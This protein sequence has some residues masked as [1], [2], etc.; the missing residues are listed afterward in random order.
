MN[1]ITVQK[2]SPE[3]LANHQSIPTKI[4]PPHNL[5][6]LSPA[7]LPKFKKSPLQEGFF[8]PLMLILAYSQNM[9]SEKKIFCPLPW[10]SLCVQPYG[11]A[12]CCSSFVDMRT[13]PD[14][15]PAEVFHNS[16]MTE[17]RRK[18][19][20]GEWP[21]QCHSCEKNERE[22]TLSYRELLLRTG[23]YDDVVQMKDTLDNESSIARWWR[24]L[25]KIAAPLTTR[26]LTIRFLELA[27]SNY[28]NLKCRMCGPRF[29]SKWNEDLKKM[30]DSGL[31]EEM[32]HIS[33]LD[34][35]QPKEIGPDSLLELLSS[36]PKIM[37]KGGEPMLNRH[38]A[39]VIDALTKSGKIKNTTLRVTTNGIFISEWFYKALP[40]FKKVELTFSIDATGPLNKYIRSGNYRNEDIKIHLDKIRSIRPDCVITVSSAYQI[41]NMLSYPDVVQEYSPWADHFSITPVRNFQLNPQFVPDEL[42]RIAHSRVYRLLERER[43]PSQKQIW[44]DILDYLSV[45]KFNPEAW[46]KFIHFTDVLDEVRS[47]KLVDVEPELAS[48]L[49]GDT[50]P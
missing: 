43:V 39:E 5:N 44:Q 4:G 17:V 9:S 48:F 49:T 28:C 11:P 20:A 37:M 40:L 3:G 7:R 10:T 47:E 27:S 23:E 46:K 22:G 26:P 14:E 29:S 25:R 35:N 6:V 16:H 38:N 50:A 15:L 19:L 8:F 36:E 33:G 13:R 30:L 32:L 12:L 31:G 21:S 1:S 2:I 34:D 42:R 24:N 18:F 45:G 41:Y